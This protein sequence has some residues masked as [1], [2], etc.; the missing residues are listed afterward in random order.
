MPY[1]SDERG[2]M[3]NFP[4][5]TKDVLVDPPTGKQKVQYAILAGVATVLLGGIIWVAY[6][7]S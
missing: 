2:V 3:N 4:T 5:E 1:T 6:V 7:V